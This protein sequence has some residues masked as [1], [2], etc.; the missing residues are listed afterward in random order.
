MSKTPVRDTSILGLLGAE[1]QAN[2]YHRKLEE[3]YR[4]S[5]RMRGAHHAEISIEK[6][7]A[8]ICVVLDELSDLSEPGFAIDLVLH[9]LSS[10]AR[11]ACASYRTD[12]AHY[13]VDFFTRFIRFP[14]VN[15]L[16]ASGLVSHQNQFTMVAQ[17]EVIDGDGRLVA[18][19]SGSFETRGRARSHEDDVLPGYG[20]TNAIADL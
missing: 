16:H 9:L 17:V 4:R 7:G 8:E 11:Y 6:G 5:V 2:S 20:L 10:S 12:L 19:G 14:E 3:E 18:N 13:P 15:Q 1:S